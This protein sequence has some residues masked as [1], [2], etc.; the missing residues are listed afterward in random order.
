MMATA[1]GSSKEKESWLPTE[2]LSMEKE[3][4]NK[5]DFSEFKKSSFTFPTE[6]PYEFDSFGCSP[7]SLSSPDESVIG[8]TE[9]ESSDE[10]DFLAGLTRRLTQQ[11]TVQP[12]KWVM[13]G[14]PESTL[15]GIGSWSV[16]SNG[17]PNGVLSPPTTPFGVKNDTWDLIYAAA[18]QVARLKMS[19]EGSKCNNF[20]E[21]GS[22][23][24]FRT[25]NQETELKNQTHAGFYSSQSFGHS[26]SQMNQYQCQ[27]RQEEMLKQQCPSVW[28]RQ[29]AKVGYQAHPQH[30]HQHP[31]NHTQAQSQSHYHHHHQQQ[32]I[33]S[34]GRSVVGCENGVGCVR[35]L[36]LP[37]S[38]WP[39]L[40]VQSN[41]HQNYQQHHHS[42]SGMRAVL[43]GGS[44]SVNNKKECA[45]TG[46]FLPR[47]YG[48]NSP[49]ESKKKSACSTV[50]LPA[51]VVQALNLNFEDM[52]GHAQPR[53]N[54]GFASDYDM[55]MARRNA[56][57]AQQ[58]R[59]LRHDGV[60]LNH[61]VR[62]PQEW[63][64]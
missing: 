34:R 33:Q 46:V 17:S 4:F 24:S 37:Q 59:N 54:T 50:L 21:R 1:S 28:G 14:S 60:V 56:I 38:A 32:Q 51:K 41:Q 42:G 49:S 30:Q 31:H 18:G 58:K 55:L 16:S 8:S 53:S 9:T 5:N 13:A 25:Q 62:L 22:L 52:N 11:L 35:P 63:T 45:G 39:P 7:T 6:F 2:F 43:L 20:Q 64:Y 10:D 57:L 48:N 40:Q 15:S 3:N 12:E 26:V 27:V 19:N 47:R 29:H 36:G 61:E 23:G 44:N